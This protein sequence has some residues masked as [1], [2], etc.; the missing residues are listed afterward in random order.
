VTAANTP[1]SGLQA[2]IA[3]L[4]AVVEDAHRRLAA[5]EIVDLSALRDEAGGLCDAVATLPVR[6]TG[7]SAV[8]LAAAFDALLADLERLAET[9][10]TNRAALVEG[11]A[12]RTDEPGG[13]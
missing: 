13:R 9:F 12:A 1:T 5:G 7:E 3:N 8:A 6:P 11:L 4:R 2:R 10:R